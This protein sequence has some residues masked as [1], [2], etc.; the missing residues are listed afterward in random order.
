[1]LILLDLSSHLTGR[2]LHVLIH[3]NVVDIFLVCKI[4]TI[5]F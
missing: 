5:L 1:V 4:Y 3:Y 2:V